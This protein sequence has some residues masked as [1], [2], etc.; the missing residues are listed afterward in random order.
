MVGRLVRISLVIIILLLSA[1]AVCAQQKIEIRKVADGV[2]A[3][4]QPAEL[5]FDDSNSTIIFLEDGVLVVDT[6][7]TPVTSRAIL[8]EI[9]KLTDKPVRYVVNTHW[10]GD[11]VQGNSAYRDA[12]PDALFVAHANT[13]ADIEARAIP[14]WKEEVESIPAQL[15]KAEENLAKG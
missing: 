11:H 15:Q 5:R 13:R 7:V 10:H 3:A 6:Q 9:R 1:R 4:L 8:A 2:Y 14:A 12:Y